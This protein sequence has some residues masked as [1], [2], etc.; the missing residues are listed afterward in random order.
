MSDALTARDG[1]VP[2]NEKPPSHGV[3][4]RSWPKIIMM[5]PTLVAAIVCGIYAALYPPATQPQEGFTTMHAVNLVFM[6]VLAVNLMLLLYDLNLWGFITVVLIMAVLV[7]VVI[8][9]DYRY[10]NMW[11]RIARALSIRVVVNSAFY[12]LFAAI[13]IFNLII[14]WIITRFNYW[15]V[16]HNEIII[17]RGFMQEQER[18]PTAQARFTLAVDD[19]VEYA[20]LGAGTLIFKFADDG[21]VHRL[22]TVP[23]AHQK[24]RK[25][26]VLL[27][28]VLVT[29]Q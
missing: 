17:H 18:H 20:I 15:R 21:S 9:L 16:E 29:E 13:L 3:I 2:P 8:L 26:D 28:R 12:F 5:W 6:F 22:D 11:P 14:A 10:G 4:L 25:L 23:F 1:T 27:G 19:I 24:A 7:L